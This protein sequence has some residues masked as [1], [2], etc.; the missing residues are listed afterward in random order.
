MLFISSLFISTAA[1]NLLTVNFTNHN[2]RDRL[3]ITS[4]DIN[5]NKQIFDTPPIVSVVNTPFCIYISVIFCHYLF[6]NGMFL[7]SLLDIIVYF[8]I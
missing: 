4:P 7:F 8:I 3:I 6:F 5:N 2:T 1:V